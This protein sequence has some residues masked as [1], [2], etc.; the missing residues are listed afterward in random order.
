VLKSQAMKTQEINKSVVAVAISSA[1]L[2]LVALPVLAAEEKDEQLDKTQLEVIQ[3]TAT[4]HVT[5]LMETPLAITALNPEALTRQ[6]I[7]SVGDLTGMIPNLQFGTSNADAGV[8]ASIRGVT[9]SNF[10]Y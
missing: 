5:N 6:N 9:S 3:V 10:T 1:L 8:K 2:S 4:K 7:K